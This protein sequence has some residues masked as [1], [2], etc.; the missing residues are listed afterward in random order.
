VGIVDPVEFIRNIDIFDVFSNQSEFSTNEFQAFANS[1]TTIYSDC[2]KAYDCLEDHCYKHMSV[3]H[4]L[5]FKDPE[6]GVHTNTVEGMWNQVRRTLPKFGT[7]KE[8]YRAYL[9]EFV[10][11]NRLRKEDFFDY[12]I[13][14]IHECIRWD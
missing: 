12:F 6:T 3:K 13:D 7:K 2:W 1:P 4:S 14:H 5:H 11:R 9:E 10:I 8:Y